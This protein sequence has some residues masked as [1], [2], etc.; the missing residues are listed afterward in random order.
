[1]S[2]EQ[3]MQEWKGGGRQG[4]QIITRSPRSGNQKMANI[5][6]VKF[7]PPSVPVIFVLG[8]NSFYL[9][10]FRKKN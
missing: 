1:M 8:L 2:E 7:Q 5:G 9:Q 6:K 10:I 4:T 3:G